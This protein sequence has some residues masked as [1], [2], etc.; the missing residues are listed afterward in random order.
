MRLVSNEAT[1]IVVQSVNQ[2]KDDEKDPKE[3]CPDIKVM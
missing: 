3:Y 2:N 1:V